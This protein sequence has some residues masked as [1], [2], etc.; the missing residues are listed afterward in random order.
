MS[1][2]RGQTP[3]GIRP[4]AKP[5]ALDF[6]PW[7][8]RQPV[9]VAL[10]STMAVVAFAAVSG[11]SSVYHSQ[12]ISLATYWAS[13]GEADL[14]ARRYTPA[15]AEFRTSLLYSRDNYSYQFDLA[16]ALVGEKRTAEASA[17]LLN[18]WDREPENGMVNLELGR[19]AAANKE[20]D[21]ALRYFHNAIYATWPDDQQQSR[22][23][24]RLELI[25]YLLKNNYKP[26]AQAELIALAANV[27]DDPSRL[28]LVGNLFVQAQDYTDALSA[29]RRSLNASSHNVAALEGAGNAAFELGRYP[30]AE[31]YLQAAL[32]AGAHNPEITNR[33][34]TAQLVLQ[35]DPFR[36]QIPAAERDRE[37]IAAFGVAGDRL[38]SC[39]AGDAQP[40]TAASKAAAPKDLAAGG[41]NP[42]ANSA[43]DSA[44]SL[45]R[46]AGWAADWAKMKPKIT[47]SGLR[48]DPDLAETAM[49]SV[50]RIERETAAVCGPPMMTDRALLLISK[51]HEGN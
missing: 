11:M 2:P 38:K 40:L 41:A 36:R 23:K 35:M 50:F 31:R 46:D 47:V 37:V 8:T 51:L 5:K 43:A 42:A 9:V 28:L 30:E 16:E 14:K 12:Q 44:A 49:E 1:D 18:L 34:K 45:E 32:A 4:P 13:R 21:Q 39:E 27:D 17:Y 26:Q 19:I 20:P 6:R 22:Q 33:L 3:D 25:G 15:V 48:K 10:L 7:L 29:Y 24:A